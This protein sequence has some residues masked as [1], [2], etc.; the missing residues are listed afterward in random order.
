MGARRSSSVAVVREAGTLREGP[1]T[2]HIAGDVIVAECTLAAD[3]V[4][5]R[6]FAIV[7][8]RSKPA[9]MLR[10]ISEVNRI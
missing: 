6:V 2:V 5:E 4:A 9:P 3:V 10:V 8:H 1:M 7:A